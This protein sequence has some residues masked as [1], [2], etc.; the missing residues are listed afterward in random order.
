MYFGAVA[1]DDLVK[2]ELL[3]DKYSIDLAL[4][5]MSYSRFKRRSIADMIIDFIVK[6][7]KQTGC[8]IARRFAMFDDVGIAL[9][10]CTPQISENKEDLNFILDLAFKSYIIHNKYSMKKMILIGFTKKVGQFYFSFSEDIKKF[11][12]EEETK[13]MT[14]IE[15]FN[16][17]KSEQ[18][19]HVSDMEYPD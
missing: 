8:V 18:M 11:S 15:P 3:N 1:L 16:W 9:I 12:K 13:I 17:F 14:D 10:F 6:N 2:H 19:N 4:E 5:L 7:N